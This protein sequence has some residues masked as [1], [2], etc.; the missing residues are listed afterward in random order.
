MTQPS[1]RPTDPQAE[2]ALPESEEL[3][4]PL[5]EK[6]DLALWIRDLATDRIVYINPAYE[7]IWGRTRESLYES[8]ESFVDAI[9][10]DD[11]ERILAAMLAHQQGGFSEEYRIITPD[12]TVR[13][14][15]AR[16]FP[17]QESDGKVA[18][19]AEFA[20]DITPQKKVEE[21]LRSVLARTQERYLLSRRIGAARGA[22]DILYA[23]RSVSTFSDAQ[24]AAVWLFDQPWEEVTPSRCDIMVEWQSSPDALALAGASYSFEQY[25]FAQ[26]FVRDEPLWID[27]IQTDPRLSDHIQSLLTKLQTRSLGLFP[28]ITS[29]LWY[30]MLTIHFSTPKLLRPEDFSYFEKVVNQAAAAIYNFLLL[31]A[32]TKARQE[33]E[34]ANQVKV[35]FLAMITHELRTPLTSIKG[36]A[37]TLLAD[38]VTWDLDNQRDF[39]KTIDQEADKLTE[40]IEHLLDLSRLESG[41]L[42]IVLE[43]Q[44]L[45]SI[46][47]NALLRFQVLAGDHA[48]VINLPDGLPPVMADPQRVEQIM[49]NLVSNAAKYSPAGTQ[50]TLSAVAR[51]K[52][53][54]VSVSDQ[55]VGISP[56]ERP[57][58]FEPF[59]RVE[60]EVGTAKSIQGVGLGL[61][62]C[63][64]LVEAQGG[65]IW[66]QDRPDPGTTLSF[67]LPIAGQ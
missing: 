58:V 66:I 5:A 8:A 49:L 9:H 50:I 22:E 3:V 15:S 32:E 59:Y 57:H 30:G 61:A 6:L 16:T 56:E 62:I 44:H 54:Q 23:L 34:R 14:V 48:L 19:I 52:D 53:V 42:R 51:Q 21:T 55:G 47:N 24:R 29:N 11:R 17:I 4:R 63:K 46:I 27:D 26:L 25:Q 28:L 41:T 43:E 37:T 36:F 13:W 20:Q 2:Q 10:P 12:G 40:L 67:T 60:T 7:T 18:R 45:E 31:K 33:A 35:K 65:N 38:D 1:R 64:S 39:I